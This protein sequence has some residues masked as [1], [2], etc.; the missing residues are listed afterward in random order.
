MRR[1]QG[2][3]LGP[4]IGPRVSLSAPRR[5]EVWGARLDPVEGSEQGGNPTGA[6]R[7]V[8]VLSNPGFGRPSVYVCAP[9]TTYQDAHDALSWCIVVVNDRA[10]GLTRVSSLDA[11]QVR[12]LDVSRFDKRW[13]TLGD[14]ELRAT[15]AAL[16]EGLGFIEETEEET[17]EDEAV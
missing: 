15:L 7:P 12:A 13:G 17:P 5:G 10:N 3:P 8:A 4:N 14:A 2:K 11:S 16:A 6:P 9:F 1:P